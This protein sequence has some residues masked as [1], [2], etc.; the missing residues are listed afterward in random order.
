MNARSR[1]TWSSLCLAMALAF[2]FVSPPASAQVL[3]GSVAGTVTDK[4]GAALPNAQITVSNV[5]TGI[6]RQ[7]KTNPSGQY[8]FPDLPAGTY[9]VTVTVQGFQAVKKTGVLIVIGQVNEQDFQLQVGGVRQEVT[10]QGSAAVLQ[11]QQTD[12]HT[13]ISTYAVQNLPPNVYHNFQTLELLTPGVYSTSGIRNSYPNS[14]ADTPDRSFDINTN[15]LPTHAN[16]TR[17][18]GATDIFLW[19]PDHMVIVPPAASVEEVNVQTATYNVQKGL[20]AGAATDVV[21]KSGS[22]QF[23]VS[24]YGYHTDQALDAKNLFAPA[25]P[26]PQNIRNNDGFTVGGPIVQHKLFYF[27]NWDGYF[28]RQQPI[29]ENLIPPTDMRTGDFSAYLGAPLYNSA[30]APINVCT[31]EGATVQ[32]QEGMV[33]DPTTGDP[34]SGTG[35]CVFSSGGKLNVIP[36]NRM[37][38]GALN[39]WKLLSAPNQNVPFTIDTPFNDIQ[40]RHQAWNRNIYTLRTD[41]YPSDRQQVWLKYTMQRARLNDGSDYGIAGQGGGTGL[42]NDVAQMVTLG[43]NYTASPNMVLTGHIGFTRMSEENHLPDYGQDLGQSVL[44]LVNSNTPTNDKRYSGMPGIQISDFTTLGTAASWEPVQR[45]DWSVTLD[46]NVSWVRGAHEISFGFDAAHN[47]M[48]HWQ[49][50]IVCCPRG[51]VSTADDNT[52]LNLPSNPLDPASATQT[53]YTS[54]GGTLTPVGFDSNPWNGVAEFDLG[55]SNEV[56]NGQQYIKATNKDWQTALYVGDRWTLTPRLTANLGVRWEYFPLIT[57]DGIDKFE[58]YDPATNILKLGGIGGNPTHLGVTSSKKLFSPRVGFAY[59][60]NDSTVVRTGFGVSYD[61]LPLERPLRGFYPL[62]IGADDFVSGNSAITRFLPYANFNAT[63]NAA[64]AIPG[65]AEGVPL[66]QPP[67]GI[68]TGAITPPP[69]VT[70]GT[71]APGEFHRGYV[72]SWN[73]AVEKKL[74]SQILLNVAYVGN[75][76]VHEFNGQELNAAPFNSGANGQPLYAA[77]GRTA[78]TYAFQGYLDSHYNS[79]QVSLNRHVTTGLFLQGAYTYSHAISYVDDEGWENGLRFNCPSSP[80]MPQGCMGLNR[81][82]PSFDHTH[83]LEMAY[84]YELPFGGG[85]RWANTGAASKVLGGWQVNGIFTWM[86]GAPLTIGQTSLYLNTPWTAADPNFTGPLQVSHGRGPGQFWFNTNAFTPVTTAQFGTSGR[87]LSWLRGPGLAQLDFSLFR[88]FRV[89][90]KYDLEARA[91]AQN[92]T[93]TP[94]W[95]NPGTT[96]SIRNGV[97][98]GSFGQIFST[99]GERL[100]QLGAQ[101]SF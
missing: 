18:D 54:S 47:H 44:G 45:N 2:A 29:D 40:L 81:G 89:G 52:F 1:V 41:Y 62:T 23:H 21:T 57:R 51:F 75:H 60:F 67:A 25:G 24:L 82:A 33:F 53:V 49:P 68:S 85:K 74:P 98:A 91:E 63:A 35:R 27:G 100:V 73:F 8:R 84:V 58:L 72:E 22:D 31:T 70:I 6:Q 79:L 56:Q 92:L 97:C 95:N 38:A 26:R 13:T 88:H 39:Y 12:V 28:Q 43:D 93:N 48:N 9:T 50:E 76:F 96:C 46:E 5:A 66:I 34:T 64:N 94:H 83:M 59:Q 17:V 20:T 101:L 61:T 14:I 32:L 16:T 36:A 3:Y 87:G 37:Y 10:V 90:E 11:T 4:S 55:L 42:T 77:F 71:L 86:N 15:G 19:L 80:S 69:D 30:G 99:Y 7:T 78:D 65:L